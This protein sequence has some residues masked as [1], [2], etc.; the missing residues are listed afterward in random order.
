LQVIN[1]YEQF[2]QALLDTHTLEKRDLVLLEQELMPL[3]LVK[4]YDN[5]LADDQIQN[6]RTKDGWPLWE[7]VYNADWLPAAGGS[8]TLRAAGGLRD[9]GRAGQ[10][11]GEDHP[12]QVRALLMSTLVC[13]CTGCWGS[14]QQSSLLQSRC[15]CPAGESVLGR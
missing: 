10:R 7:L 1:I 15:W 13:S 12:L 8:T 6:A 9:P 3:M 11:P 4:A 14:S 5:K 2:V